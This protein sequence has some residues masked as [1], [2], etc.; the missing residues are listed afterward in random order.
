MKN[1]D[2]LCM[3]AAQAM[4][5]G[6][7]ERSA[8]E[9]LATKALGVL[10]QNGPYGMVLYLEVQKKEK[11]IAE[12]YRQGLLDLIRNAAVAPIPVGGANFGQ[13]V[14]WLEKAA[15]NLDNYLFIKRLWQQA[16]IYAR[17]HAKA[18]E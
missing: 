6:V 9:N 5:S 7:G 11:N 3:Q 8:K 16:L 12:K 17:Y 1:L 13:T 10:L 15:A 2:L 14:E 4:I 18:I